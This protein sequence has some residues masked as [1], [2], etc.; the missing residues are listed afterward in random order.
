M[1]DFQY[2]QITS[3][4]RTLQSLAALLEILA[5]DMKKTHWPMGEI[6]IIV[7]ADGT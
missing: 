6:L 5:R 7:M 3:K 4:I 2:I 1:T